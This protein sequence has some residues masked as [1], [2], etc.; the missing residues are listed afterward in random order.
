MK[1]N[2]YID[3]FHRLLSLYFSKA[4]QFIKFCIVGGIGTIVNL[5]ILYAMV[6]FLKISYIFGATIAFVVAV[7]NNY[8]LNKLWTFKDKRTGKTFITKQWI[9]FLSISVISLGANLAALYLLVEFLNLWY[10][11]AQIIAILASLGINFIGNKK[12]TFT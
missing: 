2:N 12:W 5:A 6:E 7:I 3:S 11:F 8:I 4:K 1:Q 9:K 10:I